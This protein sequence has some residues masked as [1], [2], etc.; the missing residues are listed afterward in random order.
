MLK[1]LQSSNGTCKLYQVHKT[2][3]C[4]SK[5]AT[6]SSLY[7]FNS[8]TNERSQWKRWS[9]TTFLQKLLAKLQLLRRL[10]KGR[11]KNLGLSSPSLR[12]KTDGLNSLKFISIYISEPFS[13]GPS[14][15][16]SNYNSSQMK[17]HLIQFSS[18]EFKSIMEVDV[19]FEIHV[20][21]SRVTVFNEIR[22]NPYL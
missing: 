7:N 2:L 3:T 1:T 10:K 14:I 17:G 21:V 11:R 20:L 22:E 4:S 6:L 12:L 9:A 8:Q 5:R 19:L 15:T 16:L 13:L 18:N